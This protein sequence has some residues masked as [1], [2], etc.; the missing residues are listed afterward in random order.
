MRRSGDCRDA[1]IDYLRFIGKLAYIGEGLTNVVRR[2]TIVSII[3]ILSTSLLTKYQTYQL[4]D[5]RNVMEKNFEFA[6]VC[7]DILDF[8][9]IV[10]LSQVRD[11]HT[12]FFLRVSLQI[13]ARN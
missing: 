9:Y 13:F 1:S 2:K 10:S 5:S 3:G 7:V 6:A 8:F 11:G 12:S 4:A